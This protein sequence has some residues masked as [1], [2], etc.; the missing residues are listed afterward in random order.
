MNLYRQSYRVWFYVSNEIENKIENFYTLKVNQIMT[1]ILRSIDQNIKHK[2][3]QQWKNWTR[4]K[5]QVE[6][7]C[8]SDFCARG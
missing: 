7:F 4:E 1:Q 6:I 2:L 5:K 8:S 3:H